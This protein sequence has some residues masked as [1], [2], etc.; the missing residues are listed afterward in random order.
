MLEYNI[1]LLTKPQPDR[2]WAGVLWVGGVTKWKVDWFC[3]NP[4]NGAAPTRCLFCTENV[5]VFSTRPRFSLHFFFVSV[6]ITKILTKRFL[7]LI[8]ILIILNKQLIMQSSLG[9][10]SGG[11][12]VEG[13]KE[14]RVKRAK[15][16]GGAGRSTVLNFA[17]LWTNLRCA[18]S[19]LKE[20][21]PEIA[22]ATP[23]RPQ[24]K[25]PWQRQLR[26]WPKYLQ[27]LP[28]QTI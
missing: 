25:R 1:K 9:C 13:N 17:T 14:V 12:I 27:L 19:E 20:N 18:L 2:K 5:E 8:I 22:A 10:V 4:I 24:F 16:G 15:S 3:W 21:K 7:L 26:S 11:K 28:V 6:K 23:R